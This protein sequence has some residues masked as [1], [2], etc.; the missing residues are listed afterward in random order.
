MFEFMPSK[1]IKLIVITTVAK[2]TV[3]SILYYEESTA[4]AIPLR[5]SSWTVC[6]LGSLPQNV[7]VLE[8]QLQAVISNGHNF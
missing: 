1:E 5:T 8:Q 7:S 3:W 2:N 4:L 6:V